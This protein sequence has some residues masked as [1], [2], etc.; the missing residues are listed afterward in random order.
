ML[1]TLQVLCAATRPILKGL[2]T[3]VP[4]MWNGGVRVVPLLLC[5]PSPCGV[6]RVNIR[7]SVSRA[8]LPCVSHVLTFRD[9]VR[10]ADDDGRCRIVYGVSRSWFLA[11]F[12][13]LAPA[14]GLLRS[15]LIVH[16]LR[17][18]QRRWLPWTR[19]MSLDDTYPD[20]GTTSS[21]RAPKSSEELR[22]R[23]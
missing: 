14:V 21:S 15:V 8:E 19:P 23:R 13:L 22:S 9:L 6:R 16:S 11:P 2:T 17:M 4:I 20:R 10:G 12:S 3:H 5:K 18:M 7:Y 1:E